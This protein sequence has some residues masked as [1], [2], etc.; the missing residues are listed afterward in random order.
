MPLIMWSWLLWMI[1]L[2]E[3]A[4]C[5][6]LHPDVHQAN[7]ASQRWFYFT[8][9]WPLGQTTR[10]WIA[11]RCFNKYIIVKFTYKWVWEVN[12]V[13]FVLLKKKKKMPCH[14][15]KGST[16]RAELCML[17]LL[18]FLHISCLLVCVCGWVGGG[19]DSLQSCLFSFVLMIH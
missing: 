12:D 16:I 6:L 8:A 3:A 4:L 18:V 11:F 19:G 10:L 9:L 14:K 5:L 13:H 1:A 17:F 7:S 2:Q 15:C